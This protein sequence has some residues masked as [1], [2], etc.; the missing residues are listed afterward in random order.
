[1]AGGPSTEQLLGLYADMLRVRFFEEKIDKELFPAGLI[2]GL[3]HLYIGQEATGVGVIRALEPRDYVLTTHRGHGHCLLRGSPPARIFAEILGRRDGL[4]RGKGGSMHLC[5]M[6]LSL[7]GENPVVAASIPIAA[8][9]GLACKRLKNG[10]IVGDFFGEGAMN[11]GAFHEALNLA[12]LWDLPVLFLCENNLYAIS[13]PVGE[14]SAVKDL[15]LRA[16]AYG[17]DGYRVD[18]MDVWGVYTAVLRAAHV[19]RHESRP[20]LLVFDTYRFAGHHTADSEQYRSKEEPVQVFRERDPIHLLE[21]RMLDNCW[22]DVDEVAEYRLRIRE[23]LD[24]AC[25]RA[26][27]APWPEPEE[28]LEGVYV[29]GGGA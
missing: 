8:G 13:V 21:M 29:E 18:G 23:E 26:E 17:M 4:C 3:T 5:D 2:R 9:V 28:A 22:L 10:R 19:A 24:E 25:A 27:A 15:H 1:V 6:D 16:Q 7:I 14:A 12:A 11:N 20:T